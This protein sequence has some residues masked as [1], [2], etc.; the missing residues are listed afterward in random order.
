MSGSPQTKRESAPLTNTS[1]RRF[2]LGTT[3][4]FSPASHHDNSARSGTTRLWINDQSKPCLLVAPRAVVAASTTVEG[5]LRRTSRCSRR[6]RSHVIHVQRTKCTQTS[7][8]APLVYPLPRYTGRARDACRGCD[9]RC[10]AATSQ[11]M[12]DCPSRAVRISHP[13]VVTCSGIAMGPGNESEGKSRMSCP[14][15][16]QQQQQQPNMIEFIV[17]KTVPLA[18]NIE[19]SNSQLLKT[20]SDGEAAD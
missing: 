1:V 3:P 15:E 19:A 20:T 8:P 14:A 2:S 10:T 5:A 16:Q 9:H 7:L 17:F 11:A 18:I 6:E 4:P 12:E 13:W